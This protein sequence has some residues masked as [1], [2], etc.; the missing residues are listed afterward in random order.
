MGT[1]RYV[2]STSGMKTKST[3]FLLLSLI[4]CLLFS[5]AC[6][7]GNTENPNAGNT[8]TSGITDVTP[9]SAAQSSSVVNTKLFSEISTI[10]AKYG[11]LSMNKY[12]IRSHFGADSST[13]IACS[14]QEMKWKDVL[15]SYSNRNIFINTRTISY[16][17][18][19]F[20]AVSLS[21]LRSD[22][23]VTIARIGDVPGYIFLADSATQKLLGY[24]IEGEPATFL[25]GEDYMTFKT[26]AES[27][28]ASSWLQSDISS[29]LFDEIHGS[30]LFAGGA[31]AWSNL[32]TIESNGSIKGKYSAKVTNPEDI[33]G[34]KIDAVCEYSGTLKNVRKVS[35][36]VYSV[37]VI[38]LTHE[39]PGEFYSKDGT[40]YVTD[41]A[42]GLEQAVEI[43]IYL[44]GCKKADIPEKA[45]FS[46]NSVIGS[47]ILYENDLLLT[48]TIYNPADEDGYAGFVF[49]E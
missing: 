21:E 17:G 13:E 24:I 7:K 12:S 48:F 23:A 8:N 40:T 26:K 11:I 5:T 31:G 25:F 22:M 32:L 20:P 30:Y 2:I 49:W 33:N 34:E 27:D 10:L 37:Q 41:T 18:S 1:H 15:N 16:N 29:T 42:R 39:E 45:L 9:T 38:G 46:F 47:E 19:I 4:A 43:L 35:T 28:Y 36:Y 3:S 6:H 44:P 14:E